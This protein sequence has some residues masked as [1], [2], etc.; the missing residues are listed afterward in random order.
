VEFRKFAGLLA[1]GVLG[2]GLLGAGLSATFTDQATARQ[3]VQVGIMDIQ[4]EGVTP[5]SSWDGQTLV[6]PP[7]LVDNAYGAG[8]SGA[9]IV[10]CSFK[11]VAAGNIPPSQV[12]ISMVASTNGAHLDRFGVTPSG[13]HVVGG[14]FFWLSTGPQ[15][16]GHIFGNELP[17][18]VNVP[19]DWGENAGALSLDNDD[20]GKWVVVSYTIDA[21]A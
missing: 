5:G 4:L 12:N 14:P 3:D 19:V 18:T 1:V 16:L 2:V 20:M 6:C 11:V 15:P 17:A 8:M 10:G 7:V 13:F 9:P 21:Q